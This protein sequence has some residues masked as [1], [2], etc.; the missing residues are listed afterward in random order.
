MALSSLS[1]YSPLVFQARNQA[2]DARA[3]TSA[4]LAQAVKPDG[5]EVG[6]AGS[7]QSPSTS[8]IIT[9][10][11]EQ[12][13]LAQLPANEG[14]E[15]SSS[16]LST[17]QSSQRG[18]PI[19]IPAQVRQANRTRNSGSFKVSYKTGEGDVKVYEFSLLPAIETLNRSGAAIPESKPGILFRSSMNIKKFNV[20]GSGPLYQ[21]LGINQS[22]AQ[23]VGTF[24]GNESADAAQATGLTKAEALYPTP[25]RPGLNSYKTALKFD[26]DVVQSGR[27]VRI[28]ITS[29]S[30]VEDEILELDFLCYVESIRFFV[31]RSDRS[32]YALDIIMT[33][34]KTNINQTNDYGVGSSSSSDSGSSDSNANALNAPQPGDP[35]FIGPV[36]PPQPGDPELIGPPLPPVQGQPS[37]TPGLPNL[38]PNAIIPFDNRQ[39]VPT[40]Q[41]P[42]ARWDLDQ[43]GPGEFRPTIGTGPGV[44]AG[45]SYGWNV[46]ALQ[47]PDPTYTPNAPQFPLGSIAEANPTGSSNI[48]P[49]QYTTVG[50]PRSQVATV[51]SVINASSQNRDR[52]NDQPSVIGATGER[53]RADGTISTPEGTT[54]HPNGSVT[55]PNGTPSAVNYNGAARKQDLY[56]PQSP[57]G[58]PVS[59]PFF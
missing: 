19:P 18:N 6:A 32:Y 22:I 20:P 35:D 52:N 2:G 41:T 29:P 4:Q 13:I 57:A 36:R 40:T 16:S 24:I 31:A 30:N 43:A 45:S 54:L 59:G 33:R 27:E 28:Q 21:M 50:D 26:Q 23:L 14:T 34:H 46:L 51:D 44:V 7:Q 58:Q 47:N 48:V 25:T 53:W 9:Q 11:P 12:K 10:Q 49:F 56:L 8:A 1:S 17:S 55:L 38:E 5:L 3:V 42:I 15:D 39:N 37:T